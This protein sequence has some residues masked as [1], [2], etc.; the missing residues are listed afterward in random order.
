MTIKT[1]DCPTCGGTGKL[2]V[3]ESLG[4]KVRRLRREKA[5]AEIECAH[6]CGLPHTTQAERQAAIGFRDAACEEFHIWAD[7]YREKGE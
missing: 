1:T 2:E 3:R 4:V 5:A 7:L 6:V